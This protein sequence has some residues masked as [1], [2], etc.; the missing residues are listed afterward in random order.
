MFQKL[1]QQVSEFQI[2]GQPNLVR[3]SISANEK[4]IVLWLQLNEN[5]FLTLDRLD[6][7]WKSREQQFSISGIGQP[8]KLYLNEKGNILIMYDTAKRYIYTWLRLHMNQ[9]WLLRSTLDLQTQINTTSDVNCFFFKNQIFIDHQHTFYIIKRLGQDFKIINKKI[10]KYND[11]MNC[12]TYGY[13]KD[14]LAEVTD[15][16]VYF[17]RE[18][19]KTWIKE[20][21]AFYDCEII[22]HYSCF[23]RNEVK[24][25]VNGAVWMIT[26]PEREFIAYEDERITKCV[27]QSAL[28]YFFQL[29]EPTK[30]SEQY[31]HFWHRENQSQ[32]NFNYEKLN[33]TAV[34]ILLG[35]NGNVFVAMIKSEQFLKIQI[36]EGL[37]T[38]EQLQQII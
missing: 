19:P 20:K 9:N 33:F 7:T 23:Q 4:S 18:D 17:W 13:E 37:Q 1:F 16:T 6:G 3:F 31:I 24:A 36:Y 28:N 34:N 14:V 35:Q 26:Y 27:T 11:F 8:F 38:R 15:S 12:L 2:E 29:E 10:F 5:R 30:N 22:P 32:K 21:P 25:F